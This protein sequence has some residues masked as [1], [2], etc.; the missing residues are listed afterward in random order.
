MTEPRNESEVSPPKGLTI[1][2]DG[3]LYERIEQ[4]ARVLSEREHLDVNTTDLIRRAVRREVEEILS[5]A[6]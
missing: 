4:A 1:R 3:D 6:A 5:H 2:W